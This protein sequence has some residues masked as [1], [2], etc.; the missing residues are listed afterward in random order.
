MST[1]VPTNM[2]TPIY[3]LSGRTALVTGGGSGIG[4]ATATLLAK[5]GA[6]VVICGSTQTRLDAAIASIPDGPGRVKGMVCDVAD[7]TAVE[8]MFQE[9]ESTVG[10]VDILV[11]SA[12][13]VVRAATHEMQE[14]DWNRVIATNLNGSWLTMKFALRQMLTKGRGSIVNVSST[15]GLV[16]GPQ[17]AAYVASKHGVIGLTR[18]AALEYARQNIRINAVCP[19]W[20]VTP[21]TQAQFDDDTTRERN[22]ATMPIGRAG[23]PSEVAEAI[24]WLSSDAASLV[25]GSALTVDGGQIA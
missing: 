4:L 16:G 13:I 21:L 19:G 3:N 8:A 20:V 1:R 5:C 17:L 11:N 23:E 25:T 7:A 24:V 10:L 2:S 22:L 9:I 14:Q 12:G 6:T 18:A 15:G